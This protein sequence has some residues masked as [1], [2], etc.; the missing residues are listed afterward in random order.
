MKQKSI[1]SLRDKLWKLTRAEADTLYAPNCYT[2][3]ATGLVGSNKQLG[4]V[5][6]PKSVLPVAC[7]YDLRFLRWQCWN[8]NLNRGGMG[9]EALAR[10]MH[11]NPEELADMERDRR[12]LGKADAL[13]FQTKIA[14]Y[15]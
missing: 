13:F 6:W 15:A 7:Q 8:C 14:E 10:M 12:I 5:P 1:K 3:P 4:H 2:C 9:A 11:E